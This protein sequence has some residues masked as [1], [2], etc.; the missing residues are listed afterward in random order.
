MSEKLT[1]KKK[2]RPGKIDGDASRNAIIVNYELEVAYMNEAGEV[3][4][5]EKKPKQDIVALPGVGPDTDLDALADSVISK[6]KFVTAS[7]KDKVVAALQQIVAIQSGGGEPPSESAPAPRKSRSEVASQGVEDRKKEREARRRKAE[8]EKQQA[9]MDR[10]REIERERV[11]EEELAREREMEA[12]LT[13]ALLKRTEVPDKK[14]ELWQLDEYVENLYESMDDKITGTAMILQLSLKAENLEQMSRNETLFLALSRTLREDS[15]KSMDLVINIMYIFFCFSSYSEF[16]PVLFQY[17]IGDM[18]MKVIDLEVKRHELRKQDLKKM[19]QT[20][21]EGGSVGKEEKKTLLVM[22]KQDKLLY[23]CFHLLLNLAEDVN[24]E[25]KMKKRKIV[26]Y[27]VLMLDRS[28][29]ELL[30]LA[31]MFL[32]KLSIFK[33]NVADMLE[34]DVVPRLVKFIASENDNLLG[35]VLRLLLNL[36]FD[37]EALDALVDQGIIPRLISLLSRNRFK[38]FVLRLLYQLSCT[39]RGKSVFALTEHVGLIGDNVLQSTQRRVP[40]E[41]VALAINLT[42]M[43]R[44]A[45]SMAQE[46]RLPRFL[47]RAMHTGDPLLMKV[48]RNMSQHHQLTEQLTEF[49]YDL[50]QMCTQVDNPELLVECLGVLGNCVDER[51]SWAK[52]AEDL[53]MVSFLHKHLVPGFSE[54]DIVLEIIVIL[55]TLCL[56]ADVGEVLGNERLM[57][58]FVE[59]VMEKQDDADILLQSIYTLLRLLMIERTRDIVLVS[60]GEKVVPFLVSHFFHRDPKIRDYADKALDFVM[61]YDETWA[62]QIR[63]KKF[64]VH[65]EAWLNAVEAD[66]GGMQGDEYFY[67]G[68]TEQYNGFEWQDAGELQFVNNEEVVRF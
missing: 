49:V 40:L 66:E 65:N 13:A 47:Q 38:E 1:T 52:I 62:E 14:A 68:E 18:T 54:D 43:E 42:D 64:Q 8:K 2:A 63:E 44:S 12:E 67:E 35:V 20:K 16:H 50:A 9:E 37:T 6:S 41:L 26:P 22:K 11:R 57:G 7:K 31:C 28:D 56:D 51:I 15:K 29:E 19:K 21:E 5:V 58:A 34:N 30:V 3:V 33:E 46:H 36:S 32:K 60:Y 45:L 17:K 25:R 55:G 61:E 10:N 27:L 48:V 59:I 24:I 4:K 53:D 39:D 23:L